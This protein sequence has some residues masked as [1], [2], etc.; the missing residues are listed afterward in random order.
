[1][2]KA[3]VEKAKELIRAHQDK[4]VVCSSFGKD[5][6]V[7]LQLVEEAGFKW[8]VLSFREPFFPEKYDFANKEIRRRGLVVYDYPPMQVGMIKNG[9]RCEVINF[10]QIGTPAEY[11][12]LPTGI[13]PPSGPEFLC[14]LQDL[15]AKPRGFYQFPWETLLIGHKASDEDPMWGKVKITEAV[16]KQAGKTFVYPLIDFTDEDIWEFHRSR[17]LPIHVTRYNP[18]TGAEWPDKRDNPDYFPVCTACVNA[19]GPV[20]CPK[21]QAEVPSFPLEL[22]EL[23]LPSYIRRE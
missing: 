7:L 16:R 10:H 15:I 20:Q 5:S 12:T 4:P 11:L 8:P 14:V 2:L 18:A 1:M 21:L 22:L 17:E 19:E 3:K 13:V 6:M 9:E 23:T